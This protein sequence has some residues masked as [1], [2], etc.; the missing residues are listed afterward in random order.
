M[1]VQLTMRV[2]IRAEKRWEF[3]QNADSVM[4]E[5][6]NT[7]GCLRCDFYQDYENE[8]IFCFVQEW[9][10]RRILDE[11]LCSKDFGALVGAAKVLSERAEIKVAITSGNLE[12][13]NKLREKGLSN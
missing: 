8:D 6:S 5:L 12:T 9:K 1:V 4:N 2:H 13:I 7:N 10:S 3:L 11:Y